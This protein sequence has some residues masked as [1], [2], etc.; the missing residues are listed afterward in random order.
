[1]EQALFFSAEKGSLHFRKPEQWQEGG[2]Q[3]TS[4]ACCSPQGKIV[5]IILNSFSLL[6]HSE[7]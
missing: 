6:T 7:Q 1:M 5:N 4:A 2:N 3:G